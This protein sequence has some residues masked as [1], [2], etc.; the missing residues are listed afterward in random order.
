ML[1][2]WSLRVIRLMVAPHM[3]FSNP[4]SRRCVDQREIQSQFAG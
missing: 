3:V 2:L 4:I 1:R